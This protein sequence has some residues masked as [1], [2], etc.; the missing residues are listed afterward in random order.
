MKI[1]VSAIFFN[2]CQEQANFR[3]WE[4]SFVSMRSYQDQQDRVVGSG[5]SPSF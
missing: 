2:E 3:Y 5:F 1:I 4:S